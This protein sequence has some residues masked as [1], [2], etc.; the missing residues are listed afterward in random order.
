METD[1][2]IPIQLSKTTPLKKRN[3]RYFYFINIFAL[4]VLIPVSFYFG[5]KYKE[6]KNRSRN[7]QSKSV[8]QPKN[9][10]LTCRKTK[11]KCK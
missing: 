1:K 11:T 9:E 8:S 7:L 10:K 6:S 3:I 4:I 5:L 2:N